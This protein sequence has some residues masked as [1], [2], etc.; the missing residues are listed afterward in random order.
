M[1]VVEQKI[2]ALE[3]AIAGLQEYVP[4]TEVTLNVTEANLKV[5]ETV[6][7]T[8]TVA[9][10]NASQEVLWV[11]DAEGIASVDSATGLVT[12]NSAGTAI[13]T[14]TSTMNPEKKAQCTVVV[15]RDDTTLDVAIKAAEEKIREENFENKYTEASKTALRENWR[16]RNLRKRTRTFLWKM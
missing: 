7:L 6:Q 13:I 12:A 1:V 15:T 11:S 8:A 16:M 4:V 9:P 14:A 2:T 3:Q 10:D 5:G